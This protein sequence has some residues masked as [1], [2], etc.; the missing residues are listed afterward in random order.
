MHKIIVGLSVFLLVLGLA[1]CCSADPN[2]NAQS[3]SSGVEKSAGSGSK[4]QHAMSL[5]N[6]NWH[7]ADFKYTDENGKPFGLSDL[8][9]KVWLA[10]M[11][12]TS[13]TSICPVTTAH[14]ANLQDK[15]KKQGINIQ[16]VSFSVDPK[17]DKPKVMKAYGKKFG[18]DFT[19]WHFL[20]GYSF[21]EIKQFAKASFKS[22]VS[23]IANTDQFT[24]SASFFLMNQSG[25]VMARY[26]GLKPPYDQ[27][28]KDV[29]KLKASDGSEIVTKSETKAAN[30]T[31]PQPLTVSI[32]SDP[33]TVKAGEPVT[34]K[35]IVKEGGKRVDSTGKVMFKI[36]KKGSTKNHQTIGHHKGK[37]VY[38]LQ[39][40]FEAPG[41]YS[42]MVMTAV[43][44]QTAMPVKQV[45]V[46]K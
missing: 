25:K 22:P 46:K 8:K 12:F 16:I 39:K 20:T 38:T 15:L 37:G 30:G 7:V 44:G 24:H 28:I 1:G 27:I 3:G 6:A 13:C 32:K 17:R 10:D 4:A 41:T 21:D 18:A 5:A 23:K 45:K 9:G 26:D 33:D 2:K 11:I 43:D 34:L 42:V 29:K 19:R 31:M 14:M 40:T 36:T 35:A